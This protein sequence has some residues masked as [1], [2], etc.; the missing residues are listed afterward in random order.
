MIFVDERLSARREDEFCGPADVDRYGSDCGDDL[1]HDDGKA[2]SAGVVR[3]PLDE[4][5]VTE[6][7]ADERAHNLGIAGAVADAGSE[8]LLGKGCEDIL[9]GRCCSESLRFAAYAQAVPNSRSSS[10]IASDIAEGETWTRP[11]APMTMVSVS[12]L[13]CTPRRF[14]RPLALAPPRRE[15]NARSTPPES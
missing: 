13:E 15:R 12:F 10:V 9:S 14:L 3:M 1:F 6:T 5:P 2:L 4:H 7:S 11:A 8:S